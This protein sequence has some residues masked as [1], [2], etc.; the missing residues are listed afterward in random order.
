MLLF[1]R[2]TIGDTSFLT[3]SYAM[4]LGHS[5]DCRKLVGIICLLSANVTVGVGTC[6]KL[7][8]WLI[9]LCGP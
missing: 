9:I 4:S 7:S 3:R 5:G 2:A 6:V 8:D 1:D